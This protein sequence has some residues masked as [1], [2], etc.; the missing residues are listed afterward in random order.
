MFVLFVKNS[1]SKKLAGLSYKK[2]AAM[3]VFGI[4]NVHSSSN[5]LVFLQNVLTFILL[6]CT[7]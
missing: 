3:I 5:M 2:T 6:F 4:C 7:M 1:D